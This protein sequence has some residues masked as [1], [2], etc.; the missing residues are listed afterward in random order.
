MNFLLH[1]FKLLMKREKITGLSHLTAQY[2]ILEMGPV[3]LD[4]LVIGL[5]AIVSL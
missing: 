2:S 5:K 3:S 1:R 4:S